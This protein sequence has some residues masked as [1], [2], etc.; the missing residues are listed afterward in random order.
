MQN[1]ERT[2]TAPLTNRYPLFQS[3]IAFSLVISFGIHLAILSLM[4]CNQGWVA[5]RPNQ[6]QILVRVTSIPIPLGSAN[7]TRPKNQASRSKPK[8]NLPSSIETPVR[9]T[10][11]VSLPHQDSSTTTDFSSVMIEKIQQHL[12]YPLYLRARKVEGTVHLRISLS[13]QGQVTHSEVSESSGYATLDQLALD[14]ILRASPYPKIEQALTLQLPIQ[15][16]IKRP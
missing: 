7:H 9:P 16:K 5:R 3:E 6:K 8:R 10:S 14:A 15:F 1:R 13:T 2:F 4:I 12:T 11:T